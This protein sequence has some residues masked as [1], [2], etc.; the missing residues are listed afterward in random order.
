MITLHGGSDNPDNK[1][2]EAIQNGIS[3]VNI[4][5]DIKVLF[6]HG[7]AKT[8]ADKPGE[9]EPWSMTSY[10]DE[11]QKKAIAE[12]IRLFGSDHEGGIYLKNID[13]LTP[14]FH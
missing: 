7:I 4:S 5:T 1:I 8:V 6:Y 2:R 14:Y 13:R 12:K 11:T 3:K 10:A 9:Y